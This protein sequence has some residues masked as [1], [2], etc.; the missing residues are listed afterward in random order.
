VVQLTICQFVFLT[1]LFNLD[2]LS[3]LTAE[4]SSSLKDKN[5]SNLPEECSAPCPSIPWGNKIVKP[6]Y[7]P[8]LVSPVAMKLSIIT[9]APFAK[10][11]N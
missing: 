8:H 7:I 11:P 3:D 4:I 1:Y 2:V 9:W 10:S 6:D 5:L